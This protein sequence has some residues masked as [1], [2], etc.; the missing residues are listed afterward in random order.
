MPIDQHVASATRLDDA[1]L[2]TFLYREARFLDAFRLD[3]WL[4]LFAPDGIYWI[5]IDDTKPISENTAIVYDT[6]LRRE[7]R[8]H[9][10]LR[11][12]FPSQRPR[13]RTLHF[14]TNVECDPPTD[15]A[16]TVRSNQLIY[17]VRTGDYRQVGLGE[18]RPIVASVTH[19]LRISDGVAKIALKKILLINRDMP[20]YNLTFII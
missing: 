5:P 19:V 4:E 10:H 18:L 13:S 16:V 8:V 11:V 12:D 20:L 3:E 14:I 17:E 2:T 15:G 6:P 9:H 1:A 7:E